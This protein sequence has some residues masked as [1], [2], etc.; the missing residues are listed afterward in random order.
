[1][2]EIKTP[3]EFLDLID[4]QEPAATVIDF[5][6]QWCGPCKALAPVLQKMAADYP[7]VSF[8][9][10]D[11]DN[12]EMEEIQAA[13]RVESLPTICFYVRGKYLTKV[14]GNDPEGIRSVLDQIVS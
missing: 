12:Q 14:V 4:Q 6:A 7:S 2:R 10:V 3:E 9:K 5:Y 13:N 8:V 1:M 11:C